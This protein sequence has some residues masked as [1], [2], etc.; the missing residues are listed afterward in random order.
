MQFTWHSV[1]IFIL[2]DRSLHLVSF[3]IK[4]RKKRHKISKNGKTLTQTRDIYSSNSTKQQIGFI[5]G[6]AVWSK[7]KPLRWAQTP[8]AG[9]NKKGNCWEFRALHSLR[10]RISR[11]W[12]SPY[13]HLLFV[14]P[15]R[16]EQAPCWFS[17]TLHL[18]WTHFVL[19]WITA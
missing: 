6:I 12:A 14:S 11:V 5:P 3:V 13:P 2:K 10:P 19:E 1:W 4:K 18:L 9:G 8:G 15:A 7:P 16:S 17:S